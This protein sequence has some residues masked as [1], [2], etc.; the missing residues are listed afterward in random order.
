MVRVVDEPLAMLVL[1]VRGQRLTCITELA[2]RV[3]GKTREAAVGGERSGESG[4]P[5]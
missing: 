3:A 2:E 1:V 5:R 4:A